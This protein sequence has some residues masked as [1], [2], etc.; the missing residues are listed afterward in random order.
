M[1]YH[2]RHV[3]ESWQHPCDDDGFLIPLYVSPEHARAFADFDPDAECM[4]DWP[5]S[6]K[7]H[8]QMYDGI[9]KAIPV[10]P[11]FATPSDLAHWLATHNDASAGMGESF[12]GWLGVIGSGEG[13]REAGQC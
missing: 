6:V 2:A 12:E 5:A 1:I 7:T 8:L 10:S 13:K 3:T 9:A 4:P 11:I